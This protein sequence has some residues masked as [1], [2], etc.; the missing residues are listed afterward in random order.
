MM[1][2]SEIR[3]KEGE[4]KEKDEERGRERSWNLDSQ[5][6][7]IRDIPIS[8]LFLP[9]LDTCSYNYPKL[10]QKSHWEHVN[11]RSM[12]VQKFWVVDWQPLLV[13]NVARRNILFWISGHWNIFFFNLLSKRK[14]NNYINKENLIT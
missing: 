12:H 10:K 13:W 14:V 5:E 8:S 6:N 1:I 3:G 2:G 11:V 7:T 9:F 4:K